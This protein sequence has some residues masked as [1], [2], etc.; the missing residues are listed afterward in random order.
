MRILHE[1]M[2]NRILQS[3]KK[4]NKRYAV[5]CYDSNN[6]IEDIEY[7]DDKDEAIDYCEKMKDSHN[8]VEVADLV[9]SHSIYNP[10]EKDLI[11]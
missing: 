2:P 7:F 3:L 6:E 11:S 8:Y 4:N 1:S 9:I 5:K 10:Y